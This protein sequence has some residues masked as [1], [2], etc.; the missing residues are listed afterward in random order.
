MA[1]VGDLFSDKQITEHEEGCTWPRGKACL[2]FST[3]GTR[4]GAEIAHQMG[5]TSE[6]EILQRGR[7][8]VREE[9]ERRLTGMTEEQAD[10][11][12]G[13]DDAE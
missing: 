13:I 7:E 10:W 2:L 9:N 1:T 5:T 6:Q 3:D 11:E 8:E 4:L 12:E